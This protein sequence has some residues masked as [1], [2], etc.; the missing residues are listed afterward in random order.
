MVVEWD[1]EW[2]IPS[3]TDYYIAIEAMTIEMT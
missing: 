1:Y 3:G 2:E